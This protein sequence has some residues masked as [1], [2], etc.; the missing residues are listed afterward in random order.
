MIT[1]KDYIDFINKYPEFMLDDQEEQFNEFYEA[2]RTAI[3]S[4]HQRHCEHDF[5]NAQETEL[6]KDKYQTC[7]ICDFVR[8]KL[9]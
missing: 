2:I 6:Y 7:L 8:V 5:G 9:C 3:L 4:I 1:R